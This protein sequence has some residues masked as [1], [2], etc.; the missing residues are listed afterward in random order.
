VD[1]AQAQGRRKRRSETSLIVAQAWPALE[2]TPSDG[3]DADAPR[4]ERD[5]SLLTGRIT[6]RGSAISHR[7]L[8]KPQ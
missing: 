6:R 8:G 5:C 2:P 3:V 7:R 1:L 4:N